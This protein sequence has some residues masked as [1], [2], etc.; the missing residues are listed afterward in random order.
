[1]N[2]LGTSDLRWKPYH[3]LSVF[4]LPFPVCAA[5]SYSCNYLII[6]LT[7]FV[8]TELNF[9]TFWVF[10]I[11]VISQNCGCNLFDYNNVQVLL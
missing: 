8:F 5:T 11:D 2:R 9:L 1:L 6:D 3:F 4:L 7:D 10:R